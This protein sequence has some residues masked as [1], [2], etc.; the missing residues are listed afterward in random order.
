[1][2]L[3]SSSLIL[4]DHWKDNFAGLSAAALKRANAILAMRAMNDFA[5][6]YQTQ[7]RS[8]DATRVA[9]FYK[10]FLI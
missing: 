3:N 6:T 7:I 4:F 1:M 9:Q 10:F 8:G 5:L 2:L